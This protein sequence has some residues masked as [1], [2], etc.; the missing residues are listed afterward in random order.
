MTEYKFL[1]R[2]WS[3]IVGNYIEEVN[4]I[5]PNISDDVYKWLVYL[6]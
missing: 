6:S 5:K 1:D 3:Y 4:E 2:G